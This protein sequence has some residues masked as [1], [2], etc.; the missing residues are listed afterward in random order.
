MEYHSGMQKDSHKRRFQLNLTRDREG[1][2]AYMGR[3]LFG[4]Q[5]CDKK[6]ENSGRSENGS[7]VPLIFELFRPDMGTGSAG[8]HKV[9]MYLRRHDSRQL[10][11]V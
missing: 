7:Y 4:N 8:L 2:G 9:K 10:F 3:A 5:P 1:G 11:H 6:Q